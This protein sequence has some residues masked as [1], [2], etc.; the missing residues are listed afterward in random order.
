MKKLWLVMVV[1]VCFCFALSASAGQAVVSKGAVVSCP[2]DGFGITGTTYPPMAVKASGEL[3]GNLNPS[4]EQKKANK[5]VSD[6]FANAVINSWGSGTAMPGAGRFVMGSAANGD[7]QKIYIFGGTGVTGG[8]ASTEVMS[9][10]SPTDSWTTGLAAM[11]T[12]V[13]YIPAVYINGKYYLAGGYNSNSIYNLLQIYDE[14][15]NSWSTGANM[16]APNV[17]YSAAA[18]G[19]KLYVFGGTPDAH[20][21]VGDVSMYDPATDSWT[22][23]LAPMP[24]PRVYSPAISVDA[25]IYLVGGTNGNVGSYSTTGVF[26]RYDPATNTWTSGPSLNTAR[27]AMSLFAAGGYLYAVGGMATFFGSYS[28]AVERYNLADFPGGSWEVMPAAPEAFA[29]A[30]FGCVGDRMWSI[31]GYDTSGTSVTTNRYQDEGLP[32]ACGTTIPDN[33]TTTSTIGGT[34]TSVISSTTTT[35]GGG[36]TTTTTPGGSTTTTSVSSG[37]TTTSTGGAT[38][39]TPVTTTAPSTTTTTPV[40]TTTTTTGGNTGGCPAKKVLG[41]DNPQLENLRAFRDNSLAGSA[42]GRRLI[43][44]YYNNTDSINAVLDRSPALR[45]AARRVLEVIAPMVGKEE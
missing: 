40:V 34:T 26:E 24:T 38:T 32:C 37:S 4:K 30:A 12:G 14:A 2:L 42:V 18:A 11:P 25:S 6:A 10:D 22:T 7:C 15:G 44:S 21:I 43:S 33:T 17:I 35:T 16:P 5:R 45:L 41:E 3:F 23:G 28:N 19:G 9:Y 39:T 13:A 8:Q 36:T 31:G 20:S 1:A 27:G 29:F